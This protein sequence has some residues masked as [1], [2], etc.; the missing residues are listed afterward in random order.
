[1]DKVTPSPLKVIS[2]DILI[3]YFF[4]ESIPMSIKNWTFAK[5]AADKILKLII[6]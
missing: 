1:M 5:N 4:L 6:K 2:P 3:K